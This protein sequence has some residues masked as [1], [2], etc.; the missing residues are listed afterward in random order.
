MTGNVT[1][2]VVLM[3]AGIVA[4]AFAVWWRIESRVEKAKQAAYYK[5]DQ[6]NLR[7]EAAA[8]LATT[9]REELARYQ[10]H[11]AEHYVS[12]QGHREATD[13]IMGAF[14]ELRGDVRG[15]RDRID[16]F[17]DGETKASRRP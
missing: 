7:A 2:D 17:I 3:I 6:V 9:A 11:V 5:A 12:K 15:I 1:W 16:N 10:T 8:A 14:A 4:G 13:Q